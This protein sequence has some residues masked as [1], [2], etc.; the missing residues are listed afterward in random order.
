M[1]YPILF[2]G[3]FLFKFM[4]LFLTSCEINF[5]LKQSARI[6]QLEIKNETKRNEKYRKTLSRYWDKEAWSLTIADSPINHNALS[7]TIGYH[8]K[9]QQV[10]IDNN[11]CCGSMSV[12]MC[13]SEQ[14]SR[15]L[16]THIYVI[17]TRNRYWHVL[18][19]IIFFMT[20]MKLLR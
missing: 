10:T 16:F 20:I 4:C 19:H 9:W 14:I 12:C 3:K 7:S 11:L 6:N 5:V 15:L 13:V 18:I 1:I 2:A 8:Y 17:I